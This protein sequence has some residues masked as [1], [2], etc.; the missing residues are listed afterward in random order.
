MTASLAPSPSLDSVGPLGASVAAWHRR[1]A[2]VRSTVADYYRA[3]SLPHRF[4]AKHRAE[5]VGR[6]ALS[7]ILVLV[8][9]FLRDPSTPS[10]AR[11]LFVF[12]G[13]FK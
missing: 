10:P 6:I 5:S 9:H 8:L 1:S 3:H 4:G 12:M 7:C 2:V 13:L 11:G